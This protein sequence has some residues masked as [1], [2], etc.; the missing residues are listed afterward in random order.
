MLNSLKTTF[1][2]S[3]PHCR[4]E[5]VMGDYGI[6]F[7]TYLC[8]SFDGN[9]PFHL[10]YILAKCEKVFKFWKSEV[11]P[12]VVKLLK[13]TIKMYKTYFILVHH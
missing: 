4:I 7:L 10:K 8:D 11:F 3:F 6:I 13:V 9:F 5:T 12:I 2:P 1:L